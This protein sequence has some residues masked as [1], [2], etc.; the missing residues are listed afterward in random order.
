MIKNRKIITTPKKENGKIH[1][2]IRRFR[3]IKKQKN[4]KVKILKG[5]RKKKSLKN[6]EKT[7]SLSSEGKTIFS[8]TSSGETNEI[9]HEYKNELMKII[10]NIK[11]KYNLENNNINENNI[12]NRINDIISQSQK[13]KINIILDI[14]QT[15]IYSQRITDDK[16]IIFNY[17]NSFDDNHH[18]EFYLEN[19]KYVYFIQVR[20]GLKQFI[21]KLTP[22]CNFYINTIDRKSVV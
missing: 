16:D 11:Y 8:E 7:I 13:S 17:D 12:I 19:K 6:K 3:G 22:F 15:L 5:K 4:T 14:D 10:N 9:S 18:I 21:E 20:K 2:V 1:K